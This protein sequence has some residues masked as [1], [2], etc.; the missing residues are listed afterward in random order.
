[1]FEFDGFGKRLQGLRVGKNMTQGELADRLGVTGQAVSKW[2]NDLSYPDITL[3]PTIATIFDVEVNYL[4]GLKKVNVEPHVVFPKMVDNLKL[5]HQFHDVACYS[6]KEVDVIDETGVKFTD[7][8]TAELSNRLV[9]NVGKGEIR[10][11]SSED[12]DKRMDFT[13]TFKSYEFD[14]VDSLD[15]DIL[16]NQCEIMRSLDNHCRVHASGETRF[17][18]MLNVTAEDGVLTIRFFNRNGVN[19]DNKQRNSIRIELPCEQGKSM[20]TRVNGSGELTS[21][22]T[23]FEKGMLT[24]KW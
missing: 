23:Y 2:E 5:V 21:E 15:V 3:I 1:M 8:S 10:L 24:I 22:I 6:S 7:G 9:I 12:V 20:Q 13:S 16:S 19:L 4:F 14:Y 17:I 18:E 11:L